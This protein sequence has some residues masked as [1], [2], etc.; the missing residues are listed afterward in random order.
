MATQQLIFDIFARDAASGAFIRIGH[1]ASGASRSVGDLNAKLDRLNGRVA[2]ARINLDGDA[3]AKAQI[4][5]IT[6][7][8]LVLS[9]TV[10]RPDITPEGVAKAQLEI[11]ALNAALDKLTLRAGVTGAA[12][13][14]LGGGFGLL[15][16]GAA[17]AG[18][19]ITLFGGTL[20]KVPILAAIGGLHLLADAVIEVG[21]LLI[22]AA[23]AFGAFAAA[24]V[25]AVQDIYTHMKNLMTV[26]TATG[27][28]I[29]P[30]TGGFAKVAAAVRPQVY[31][32][33]G[34]ALTLLSRKTGTFS[35]LATGAGKALD[36]L[37]A[38]FVVAVTQG[39]G[40]TGFASTASHDLQGLGQVAGNIG[41]IIGN[42]L[43]E[44]PGYAQVFLS[45]AQGITHTAETI[46]GSAIGEHLIHVGLA[47]HGA[48]IYMG[49]LGTLAAKAMPAALGGLGNVLAGAG[50]FLNKFGSAGEKAGAHLVG[51][52]I[53]AER[54]SQL[55]WG[56]IAAAAIGI[57]VLAYKLIT[58]K[59]ATQQ[60]VQSLQNTL[61]QAPAVKGF[62]AIQG[63]QIQVAYR[64]ATAQSQYANALKS[65]APETIANARGYMAISH[66]VNDARQEISDLT[67]A[68]K[69]FFAQGTRAQGVVN[70]LARAYGGQ[71]TALGLL[72]QA[73]IT[74][75]QLT[76]KNKNVIEQLKAQVAATAAAYKAMG[77]K[78]GILGADM[79]VVDRLAGDQYTAMQNLN[80]AW[81]TYLGQITSLAGGQVGVEQAI[82]TVTSEAKK[83]GA[84]FTGVNTASLNLQSTLF[85]SLLPSLQ[86]VI[87]GMRSSGA[88]SKQLATVIS[89]DLKPAV[90]Q[91]ALKNV[92]FRTSL[93]DMAKEAGYTGPNAIKPL[94]SWVDGNATSMHKATGEADN[95]TKAWGRLGGQFSKIKNEVIRI[96]MTGKGA[97]TI[98]AGGGVTQIRPPGTAGAKGMLVTGGTPGRDSVPILAMPGE[99]VVPK[100]LTPAV[101]P[102]MKAHRVP[103]FAA[104]GVVGGQYQG[105]AS[106][107]PPFAY[108]MWPAFQNAMTN[109]MVTS[110]RGAIKQAAAAV[111][112][113]GGGIGGNVG[114]YSGDVLKVLALLGQPAGDLAVVLRQMTTESGGNPYIVNKWDSNWAA[115]TPSVG[116]MQV[117]GPT[118]A[119]WA[120]PYR[121]VG[122]FEYGVSVNPMANIYAGLN[123]AIHRYGAAWT[124]VLGQ[125]H[126]YDR[127]GFLPTGWSAAYNGTGRPEPV[128]AAAGGT[129]VNIHVHAPLM[130][131]PRE[132]SKMI[133]DYINKGAV[134]GIRIRK[135]A[136]A[137]SG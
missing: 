82:K 51:F 91:G 64:L 23:I 89:T 130:S 19:K 74:W 100:H 136:I 33:F 30:L 13:G 120:G 90:D 88:S 103:G 83:Q 60:W 59:D 137:A 68:Q 119:T 81:S 32:L 38:R 77:Q 42:F 126:G 71:K 72:T 133:A 96:I 125:G 106:G 12:T 112:A 66:N 1:A 87:G 70:S 129:V 56:W 108:S 36:Q 122:P 135:S 104:G 110:M 53:Q 4:D 41:G 134:A 78:G 45:L 58:A 3:K 16:F 28:A 9:A 99:T 47:A 132:I 65:T 115:G 92:A 25:P 52:G 84:S 29:P 5:E 85:Q 114:S 22:P 10:A 35:Q 18:R 8:L 80:Q 128:G 61:S 105:P 62:T 46:T 14:K 75:G 102:L 2:T 49:L 55:P 6:A 26:S 43:K 54:A 118:F 127:G 48:F 24:A 50:G 121:N 7:R 117:I 113:G 44:V 76:S 111:P 116:L 31:Q 131:N 73:G 20:G 21:A 11:A 34:D 57:G 39:H 95:L 69:N 27:K 109:A 97:Y 94:T 79:R 124:S 86:G 17:A 15:G 98:K 107:L 37:G 93:Y 40:L 123:Y 67:T 63:D 101:A